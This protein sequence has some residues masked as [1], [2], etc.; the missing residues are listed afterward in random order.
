MGQRVRDLARTRAA[1]EDLGAK[2]KEGKF[3]QW[4]FDEVWELEDVVD[5]I[6][7]VFR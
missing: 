5:D 7:R 6:C 2:R 3:F 4:S 1:E